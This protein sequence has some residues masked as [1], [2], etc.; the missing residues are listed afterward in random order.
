MKRPF[1]E[2]KAT[3]KCWISWRNGVKR[4]SKCWGLLAMAGK[5]IVLS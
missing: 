2:E 5:R 1:F 3:T 4:G